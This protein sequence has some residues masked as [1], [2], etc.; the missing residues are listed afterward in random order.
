[1]PTSRYAAPGPYSPIPCPDGPAACVQALSRR[2][3][4]TPPPRAPPPPPQEPHFVTESGDKITSS[5]A[6]SKH[7]T[8]KNT[9]TVLFLSLTPPCPSPRYPPAVAAAADQA[10][11]LYP[12]ATAAEI[13]DLL[14]LAASIER[15]AA[16][17][18]EPT[19]RAATPADR[20]AAKTELTALLHSLETRIEGAD[21][22]VD[23]GVTLADIALAASLLG[24]YQDVLGADVQ[25]AT[26]HVVRWLQG[27]L[28]HPNFHAILGK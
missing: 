7:S 28:A 21:F 10:E 6:I 18:V 15:A 24:L 13:D 26:P 8:L 5:G 12:A 11:S 23:S 1:M 17:W 3:S 25:A 22:V 2:P 14:D 19:C 16:A 9:E 20:E 27:L 4:L